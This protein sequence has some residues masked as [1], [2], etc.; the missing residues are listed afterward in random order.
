MQI[1]A[2]NTQVKSVKSQH[3]CIYTTCC[4]V[5]AETSD[6]KWYQVE[7]DLAGNLEDID[8]LEWSVTMVVGEHLDP[9]DGDLVALCFTHDAHLQQRQENKNQRIY[10]V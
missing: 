1:S 6:L 5:F 4:V 7:V 2:R 3:D 8:L 9:V 10:N